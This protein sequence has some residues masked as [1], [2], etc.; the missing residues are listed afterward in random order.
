MS[1]LFFFNVTVIAFT[2]GLGIIPPLALAALL[3]IRCRQQSAPLL[4]KRD[5]LTRPKK[6]GVGMV[7]GAP[8]R[9]TRYT[10]A[11]DG[12]AWS[13]GERGSVAEVTFESK[14]ADTVN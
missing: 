6:R 10:H 8:S 5:D 13:S 2:V 9:C 4:P 11:S 1:A 12:S 7:V 14:Q 3:A